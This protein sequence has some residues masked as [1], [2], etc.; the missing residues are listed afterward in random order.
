MV[1]HSAGGRI[2][3]SFTL[4]A[5]LLGG[6]AG[7]NAGDGVD[8]PVVD[9]DLLLTVPRQPIDYDTAVRPILDNR[10]VVCHGCYDAP[11]QL[12]LSS[13]EGLQRGANPT[14]V[15]DGSRIFAAEPTR[16]FVDADSPEEWRKKGFHPVLGAPTNSPQD[17]LENSV[18]YR[19]LRLK[20]MYPQPRVGLLP[21]SFDLDLD[22]KQACPTTATFDDFARKHPQWG[23]PYA[24]PNL[25]DQDYRTLVHWIAQGSPAPAT[26]K[27]SAKAQTQ[28][29]RWERFLNEGSAKQ[30]L[31][32]RYLYEHLFLAHIHLEGTSD[33]EFY[34]LVR[35]RTPSGQ[36]VREIATIRPYDDPGFERFYYRLRLYTP[37]IVAKDHLVYQWSDQR[38]ARYRELFLE[39]DF[40]VQTLPSYELAT[41]SNPFK[42]FEPIP[43][44]SRYRFMLDD[45]RFFIDGFM[46]G[47]VCRGQ[48]ALNVIED[49]FWVFFFD[50]DNSQSTLDPAFIDQNL[51]YLVLPANRGNTLNIFSIWNDYWKRQ[52]R[53]LA[54]KHKKFSQVQA[55]DLETMVR[56]VWD[57]DGQNPNASLTAFRHF[58]SASVTEGLVGDY[59]ETAWLI[60]YPLFERIHYLLVA[61]FDVYGNV[62]HQLNT[63][64]FM[65]FLRME[66]EDNFLALL[67]A[68]RRKAI[69]DSW[70]VGVRSNVRDEFEAP[71]DWLAVEAVV[72]YESDDPQ[73]ELYQAMA[74]RLGSMAGPPD[75]LNRCEVGPCTDPTADPIEAVFDDE[76]RKIAKL[77]GEALDVF[78]D[79]AYVRVRAEQ[80]PERHVHYTVILNKAYKNITSIFQNEDQ[81]DRTSD[82]VTVMKSLEGVYPNLFFDVQA[83][84]WDQFASSYAEIRS[85][86]D[87]ERFAEVHGVRRTNP[88]FWPVADWY[89]AQALREEPLRAG[90]LDL[91]RYRNR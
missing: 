54:A 19:M 39:P 55:Q 67:P 87:Y 51:D 58:D 12:K 27:P 79:V 8:Q 24:M 13:M 15:Y 2:L 36:A 73:R 16:L 62:G 48:V 21:A 29:D 33:R 11:C 63:R 20:Q 34:R 10:C 68:D 32:S 89:Q 42:V 1:R 60:D 61:G 35:S 74:R 85:V 80:E 76:M 75:Y 43:P 38:M 26:A 14:M 77:R 17:N 78:P 50:P 41:A 71:M 70:Y 40:Q 88:K 25:S 28:I 53:Y 65:E 31:V 6:C 57:G 81:R 18:L 59:P 37:S 72:G 69:R 22:R 91:N 83:V 84:D 52:K 44:R 82:T 7:Q 23:M 3:G 30:K 4:V 56:L 66:G 45:A 90:I 64:L 86:D 46:K 5:V 49:H 47:P 9:F